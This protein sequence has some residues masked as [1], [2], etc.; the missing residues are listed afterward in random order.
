M[1]S[2]T[3]MAPLTR[4]IAHSVA[5]L[6][7]ICLISTYGKCVSADWKYLAHFVVN[8]DR[9]GI[10]FSVVCGINSCPA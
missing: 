4:R 2:L 9:E 8:T 1:A 5:L 6:M 10:R 7:V 3:T